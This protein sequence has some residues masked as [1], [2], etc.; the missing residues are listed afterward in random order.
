[1]GGAPGAI[2][3]G[4]ALD[5]ALGDPPFAA[6]LVKQP[7]NSWVNANLFLQPRA[8]AAAPL[9]EVPYWDVELYREPRNWAVLLV[10]AAS[11]EVLHRSFCDIPCDR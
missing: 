9:P 7:R 5:A 8:F 2:S 1:M 6:W 11:G 3:A 4:R 10:D